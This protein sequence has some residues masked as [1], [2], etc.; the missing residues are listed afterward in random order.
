MSL[1]RAI[2]AGAQARALLE[3]E[4]LMD[5]FAAVQEKAI[6]QWRGSFAGDTDEREQAWWL[7]QAL[8]QLRT[9]LR[10]TL[11]NGT[12]AASQLEKQEK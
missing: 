4:V 2:E 5:A 9:E 10:I 8:D 12:V 1:R 11:D 3:N 7:L 6:A